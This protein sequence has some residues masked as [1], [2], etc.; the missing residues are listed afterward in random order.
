[1]RTVTTYAANCFRSLVQYQSRVDGEWQ[2]IRESRPRMRDG[3]PLVDDDGNFIV[4]TRNLRTGQL[5]VD[6]VTPLGQTTRSDSGY[7]TTIYSDFVLHP[8]TGV[9]VAREVRVF[10]GGVP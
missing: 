8:V 9:W 3:M 2:T 6:H 4:E 7:N 1:E 5:T 10:Q